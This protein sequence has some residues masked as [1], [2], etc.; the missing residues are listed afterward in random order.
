M[1]KWIIGILI[2]LDFITK[3]IFVL[4]KTKN[5][6]RYFIIY[7]VGYPFCIYYWF[8]GRYKQLTVAV[9]VFV[10]ICL[11]FYLIDYFESRSIKKETEGEEKD[12]QRII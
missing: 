12:E 11:V 7:S 4:L 6:G 1:W 5:R 10:S 2:I 8:T 9:I 3:I